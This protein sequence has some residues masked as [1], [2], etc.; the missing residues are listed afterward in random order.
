MNNISKNTNSV[1][2][3]P[4][5]GLG[6]GLRNIHFSYVLENLP[7]VDWFEIISENFMYS[8]GKPRHIY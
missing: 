6:L 5:L 7:K 2:N 1:S 3:I 8:N 4:N